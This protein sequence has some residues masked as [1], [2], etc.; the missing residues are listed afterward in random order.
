MTN[1]KA[2][3][4]NLPENHLAIFQ[5]KAIRRTWPNEA[6]CFSVVD[7]CSVLTKSPDAVA[8]W[9]KLNQQQGAEVG[10]WT[11]RPELV[12]GLFI[13]QKAHHERLEESVHSELIEV[14]KKMGVHLSRQQA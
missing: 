1:K 14:Y 9:R 5:E 13:I 3:S 8:Y 7:V 4:S 10:I 6:R 11:V 12:E 2:A